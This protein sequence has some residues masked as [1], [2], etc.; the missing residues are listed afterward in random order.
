[1][2]DDQ[3][4]AGSNPET[5]VQV[6]VP[7]AM[8]NLTVNLSMGGLELSGISLQ[9]IDAVL[10]MGTL[11]LSGVMAG[12]LNASVSMGDADMR[13]VDMQNGTVTVDMGSLTMTGC[14]VTGQLDAEVSMGSATMDLRQKNALLDLNA[15][16]GDLTVNGTKA[17]SGILCTNTKET[18][19]GKGP[20]IRVGVS[21]G[22]LDLDL[23][24]DIQTIRE[25]PASGK[26]EKD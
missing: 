13:N 1:M 10:D 26:A 14:K 22:S 21:M 23:D 16:M 6:T 20:V 8:K 15:D 3:F 12:S 9:S 2:D 18:E 19:T 24:G 25:F 4:L 7:E 17:E 11:K 5:V